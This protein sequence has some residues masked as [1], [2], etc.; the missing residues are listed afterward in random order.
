MGLGVGHVGFFLVNLLPCAKE[1]EEWKIKTVCLLR[2]YEQNEERET[3]SRGWKG[4]AFAID[5]RLTCLLMYTLH[6][7]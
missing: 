1:L 3:S 7:E 6:Q 2:I 5:L 4:E